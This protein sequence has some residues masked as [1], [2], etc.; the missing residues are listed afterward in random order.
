M[1]P[2]YTEQENELLKTD[3]TDEELAEIL[4]RSI[5]GIQQQRRRITG[6]SINYERF[7]ELDGTAAMWNT[8]NIHEYR[9]SL[10]IGD[11]VT[12]RVKEL[13]TSESCRTHEESARIVTKYPDVVCT[14]KG[15]FQYKE[16]LKWSLGGDFE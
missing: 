13:S 5:K 1:S 2:R 15:V 3:K 9:D 14:D 11:I 10:Q 7:K 4:H 6:R 16:I 8:Q 12:V